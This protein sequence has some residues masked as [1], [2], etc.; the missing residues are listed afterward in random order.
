MDCGTA[1]KAR[2]NV[3]N[4]NRAKKRPGE[5]CREKASGYAGKVIIMSERYY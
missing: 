5:E 3:N 4:G 2:R 1:A